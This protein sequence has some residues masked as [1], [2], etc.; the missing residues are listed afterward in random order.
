MSGDVLQRVES[1][2]SRGVR[3]Q[4]VQ[5]ASRRKTPLVGQS[6]GTRVVRQA[7]LE[8][9]VRLLSR[10]LRRS[11]ARLPWSP[12]QGGLQVGAPVLLE[13]RLLAHRAAPHRGAH[14]ASVAP[15]VCR[16]HVSAGRTDF[17]A[18][19]SPPPVTTSRG[20]R[21][22]F[23]RGL[24]GV[25]LHREL[26]RAPRA[27][28]PSI[29][30]TPTGS[31]EASAAAAGVTEEDAAAGEGATVG[32]VSHSGRAATGVDGAGGV[33]APSEAARR[34]GPARRAGRRAAPSEDD[35][36]A[37]EDAAV[38]GDSHTGR[39]A[40]GVVGARDAAAPSETARRVGGG[41]WA[42]LTGPGLDAS[43]I[44]WPASGCPR[45]AWTAVSVAATPSGPNCS[46]PGGETSST[47]CKSR[48]SRRRQTDRRGAGQRG[49]SGQTA[50]PPQEE[51]SRDTRKRRRGR[52]RRGPGRRR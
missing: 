27:A 49:A 47:P 2:A 16:V 37:E 25:R 30:R 10:R 48:H 34:A 31:G 5:G 51:P 18:A 46:T 7:H 50:R 6:T 15:P 12:R 4:L 8:A 41:G 29:C 44:R 14:G 20:A 24:R 11:T 42:R 36:A 38:G 22:R 39:V 13:P 45:H 43:P 3:Q 26:G 19:G 23:R 33:T 1:G 32:G 40:G 28:E 17:T 52:Q 9:T 35:A 21:K